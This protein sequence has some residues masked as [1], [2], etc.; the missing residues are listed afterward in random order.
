MWSRVEVGGIVR[1]VFLKKIG[2]LQSLHNA[3]SEIDMLS[4]GCGAWRIWN[5]MGRNNPICRQ[6]WEEVRQPNR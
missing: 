1:V 5:R 4:A 2:E 3:K 6:T